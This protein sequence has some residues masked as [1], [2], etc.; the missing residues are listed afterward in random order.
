MIATAAPAAFTIDTK[1]EENPIMSII[2][3]GLTML[4]GAALLDPRAH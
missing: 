3:I 4:C 1:P 2:V